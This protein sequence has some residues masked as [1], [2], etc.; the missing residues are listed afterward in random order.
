MVDD[1]EIVRCCPPSDP[2]AFEA[3]MSS[4]A[5]SGDA[6]KVPARPISM[7]DFQI[8]LGRARP[9][10]SNRDLDMYRRFT[11]EHGERG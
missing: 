7:R 9:T 11:E 6:R 5:Q 4:L 1:K 8:V 3:T 10:V 2:G